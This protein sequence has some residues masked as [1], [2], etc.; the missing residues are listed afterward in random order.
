MMM[1]VGFLVV[2]LLCMVEEVLCVVWGL[3]FV[4][5]IVLV[6]VF[7]GFCWF[8]FVGWD[9]YDV[10]VMYVVF[11][12]DVVGEVFDFVCVFFECGYFYV[13]VVVE[14]NV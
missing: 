13:I 14:M 8:V 9:Y 11:G 7:V 6:V 4:D 3:L 12:D 10:V 1:V 2:V 5:L